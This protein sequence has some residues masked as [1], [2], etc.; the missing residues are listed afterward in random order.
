MRR[1]SRWTSPAIRAWSRNAWANR[2]ERLTKS[3]LS[4]E[5]GY[6]FDVRA[7]KIDRRGSEHQIFDLGSHDDVLERSLLHER[8][9]D[10]VRQPSFVDA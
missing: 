6:E 1:R 2:R 10:V 3:R 8:V 7:R 4:R 9:I 5:R